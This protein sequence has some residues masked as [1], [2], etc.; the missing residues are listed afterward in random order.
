MT[1]GS[2]R[3]R[4]APTASPCLPGT[5]TRPARLWD[6]T[7]LPDDPERVTAW[8]STGTALGIDNGDDVKLLDRAALDKS[9]ERLETLG[10]PLVTGT[11]LVAG[12][13]PVRNRSGS[14]CPGMDS[15]R[16]VGQGAWPPLTSDFEHAHATPRSGPGCARLH[17]AHGRLDKAVEDA[18]QAVLACW[19]APKLAVLARSDEDFR[20]EALSEIL[21]LQRSRRRQGP[22]VWRGRARRRASQR[23][24]PAQLESSPSRQPRYHR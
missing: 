23:D 20:D 3:S 11:P 4:S 22:E 2:T 8:V 15:A 14:L 24:G 1:D 5:R 21:Q 19:H 6:V 7:E 13:H 16:A 17:T 18:A 9:L 10:S 12:P